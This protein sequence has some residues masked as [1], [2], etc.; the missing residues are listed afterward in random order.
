MKVNNLQE[1]SESVIC[2]TKHLLAKL[3]LVEIISL[4]V[5]EHRII[6][7]NDK[8]H[9]HVQR[10]YIWN[11]TLTIS[12]LLW[13]LKLSFTFYCFMSRSAINFT[14]MIYHS[15][16]TDYQHNSQIVQSYK[17]ILG[18]KEQ[19]NI[20]DN[21]L[22]VWFFWSEMIQLLK[23]SICFIVLRKDNYINWYLQLQ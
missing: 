17:K 16:T 6:F 9:I 4:F 1:T 22:S 18:Q 11:M 2:A 20:P 13:L 7:S 10:N 23:N 15:W 5:T 8:I 3:N 12:I 14:P 21:R 19:E